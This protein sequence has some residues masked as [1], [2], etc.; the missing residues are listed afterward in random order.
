MRCFFD[1]RQLRHAPE[2]YFRWGQPIP[3]PEQPKRA[4][5]LRD[6][7]L[8][9]GQKFEQPDDL[10][11]AP[12]K[13]VH[14]ADFVDFFKTARTRWDAAVGAEISAV[15]N[16]HTPRRPATC[17]A[18][19][20]GQL[21][22]YSTDTSCAVTEGTWEAIYWSA[23]SALGA[24][25]A[26]LAGDRIAYGLS[27]PPGHHAYKNAT[28]GFCFFNN[29]A[30]A[31]QHLR[32]HFDKVTV[33]DIDTHAANGTLDIFYD[34][35]DVQVVSLH[36]DPS[37]YPPYYVGYPHETG[38]GAGL[39]ATCNVTLPHG[40]DEP[41]VLKGFQTCIEAIENFVPEA[42]VVSLGFDL[43]EDDPLS[44]VKFS[45]DGFRYMARAIMA[46]NLPTVLVQEGGYLGPSL[47][48]NAVAFFAECEGAV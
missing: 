35:A 8:A 41:A 48:E 45:T 31:A 1:P 30:I 28:N 9:A 27:R 40:A 36:V 17:P 12:L 32:Q 16:Y 23:Q 43:S 4:E 24:A 20:V 2:E 21:G 42:L 22:Y 47:S 10:G 25:G 34:R 13:A 11:E 26:V 39:G 29:A 38:E 37:D 18:G 5:L 46:L 19:V 6:V 15:P 7:L 44:V 3:H 33:L 14:D